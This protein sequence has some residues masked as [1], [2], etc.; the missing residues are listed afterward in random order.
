MLYGVPEYFFLEEERL[1]AGCFQLNTNLSTSY[2]FSAGYIMSD[3]VSAPC[4]FSCSQRKKRI[5]PNSL[6]Q[7]GVP[8]Q[9]YWT[10]GLRHKAEIQQWEVQKTTGTVKK[11]PYHNAGDPITIKSD[12]S[13]KVWQFCWAPL[14]PLQVPNVSLAQHKQKTVHNWSEY[15]TECGEMHKK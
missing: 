13:G 8:F 12:L 10:C 1:H 14:Q 9:S 3:R 15:W 4:T 5:F 2:P 6:F 11:Q 7:L